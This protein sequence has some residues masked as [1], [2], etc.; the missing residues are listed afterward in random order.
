[1]N[2]LYLCA[3]P[4][5]PVRGHKGAAVHVRAMCAAFARAG[6]AVTL[7]AARLGPDDGP[8]PAA[9]V[10]DA[11]GPDDG[12]GREV[13]ATS[14]VIAQ[15][16]AV[17]ASGD[18]DLVYERYALLSDAGV[19]VAERTGLPLVLEV[20]APLI[21]EAHEHRGLADVENA[22]VVARR[23]FASATRIAVVSDALR[24]YVVGLGADPARVEVVPNG[25]D[26]AAFHPALSGNRVR[27]QLGLQGRRVVGFVG[28]PRP[29]H[30]L[31][32]LLAAVERLHAQDPAYLLLLV[33]EMPDDVR[34]L[35]ETR[36]AWLRLTGAVAHDLVPAHI[37]A[38]HVAVSSHHARDDFYFSPLKLYEYLACAVPTIA[39][40][41]GQQAQVLKDSDGGWLYPA[42]D[43][44][45]LAGRIARVFAEPDAALA[46]AWRGAAH[47][48]DRYTWDANAARVCGWVRPA[49]APA[50][51]KP[52]RRT[53]IVDVRLRQ[54]LFK[55]TRADLA[56]PL[57]AAA[58]GA[59]ATDA[60]AVTGIDVLKY[61]PRRRAVLR[62]HLSGASWPRLIGKVFRDERA[63]RL[64]AIQGHLWDAGFGPTAADRIRVAE[65]I[66]VVPELRV[67]LQEQAPGRTLNERFAAGEALGPSVDRAAEAAARLHAVTWRVD[68]TPLGTYTLAD[69]VDHLAEYGADLVTARPALAADVA[70]LLGA[71]RGWAGQLPAPE[72][73]RP[74]HRDFYYSQVLIDGDDLALIDFD[75]ISLGDPAIDVANFMAH[76]VFL[77]LDHRGDAELL[78]PLAERFYD[79]YRQR[80]V[81]DGDFRARVDFYIAATY[82][83]LMNVVVGRPAL[84][85]LL[86]TLHRLTLQAL[87]PA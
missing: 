84:A 50:S 42:G 11:S 66:A 81:P 23:Q 70:D 14:R 82:F 67:F 31:G 16:E 38:M 24:A 1:M 54:R 58:L 78:G 17:L 8:Q 80:G 55:A 4:G 60:F 2:I 63:G 28:R 52:G 37:A 6:H 12:S 21:D 68:W 19:R 53:P 61:K 39:A 29:W 13:S 20:N 35:A 3:D 49:A 7:V 43:A 48:L 36:P 71:L 79:A 62:Y 59:R 65:P 76:L 85:P 57:L 86:E 34:A 26:P 51:V 74:V 69:E 30:D 15:A 5:I 22:A 64:A 25:V 18:F 73:L 87:L 75:L 33:G 41:V 9:R 46:M 27:E 47:V 83:R 77:G 56:A 72:A 40:D 45:A 44:A 32:T 10:I